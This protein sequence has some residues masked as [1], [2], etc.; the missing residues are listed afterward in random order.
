MVD[1]KTNWLGAF[2]GET[3]TRRPTTHQPRLAA[4]MMARA[5]P[6]AGAALRGRAAPDAALATDR[7]TTRSAISAECSTSSSAGWPDRRPRGWRR[8]V[9]RLQLATTGRAGRRAVRSAGRGPHHEMQRAVG[10]CRRRGRPTRRAAYRVRRPGCWPCSTRPG[11][12]DLADVHT[13]ATVCR[14]AGETDESVRLALALT[15]RALR[16]RLGLHRPAARVH[17][18]CSRSPRAHRRGRACPGPS[19]AAWLAR[20]GRAPWSPTAPDA[21]DGRPLRLCRRNC[22]T[23]SATGGRRRRSVAQLQR[24]FAAA[25]AGDRRAGSPPRSTGC[26]P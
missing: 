11:V 23:W 26:S 4:A 10:A 18:T 2:D 16:T 3:L 1:Y 7:T 5:L 25:G 6:A 9:R 15:V 13:A 21:P 19:P 22:S 12:L 8:S 24:R 17:A 14:I 20:C